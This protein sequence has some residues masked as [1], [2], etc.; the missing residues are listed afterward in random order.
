M[1]PLRR[2]SLCSA[3][4]LALSVVVVDGGSLASAATAPPA[5]GYGTPGF[6]NSAA[7]SDLQPTVVA[8]LP[9]LGLQRSDQD[10]AGEPSIGVNWNTGA[11]LYQAAESTYKITFDPN[12]TSAAGVHWSN[13]SSP[14]SKFNIDPILATDHLTGTTIAGGD[15]GGCAVMSVTTVDGG[16]QGDPT[17]WTPSAPCPFTVDHP[18]V[19]MGPYAGTPPPNARAPFVTYFC[20]QTDVDEC[21]H[22]LDGGLTWTPSVADPNSSKTSDTGVTV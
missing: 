12:T 11:A 6:V 3:L 14:Y 21:S 22:S 4:V 7:P 9:G 1:R 18:T 13:V 8:G 15:N 16:K 10:F 5:F 19:G 17:A 20:Q 2:T